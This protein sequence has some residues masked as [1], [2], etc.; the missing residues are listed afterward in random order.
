MPG[1]SE[2]RQSANQQLAE[3]IS[4][5]PTKN[6]FNHI[7]G[8]YVIEGGAPDV[9]SWLAKNGVLEYDRKSTGWKIQKDKEGRMVKFTEAIEK[10]LQEKIQSESGLNPEYVENRYNTEMQ[11]AKN[12]F[13]EHAKVETT[14]TFNF[15]ILLI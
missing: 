15:N 4:L 14:T 7:V 11:I 1:K 9:V 13:G 3:F 5:L 2:I 12:A 8:Q 6:S 10:K